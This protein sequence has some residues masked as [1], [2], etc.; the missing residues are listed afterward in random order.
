[1]QNNL[2]RKSLVCGIILL[3]IGLSITS[4]IGRNTNEAPINLSLDNDYVLAYWKFDTGSGNIAYDSSGNDYDGTVYG[5]TWFSHLAGYALD[6]D[7]VDDYIDLDAHSEDIGFNKTDDLVFSVWINST[8][9]DS[10]IYC[11]S[12][13]WGTSNPEMSIGLNSDGH[14]MMTAWVQACGLSLTSEGTYNNGEWH[15]VEIIYHGTT[16][17]P[18]VEL[19]VDNELDSSIKDWVCSFS[20]DQFKKAKIG[21]R[22]Y[23]A[24]KHFKGAIDRLKIIKYPG[25][26]QQPS[27]P[28]IDGPEFGMPGDELC[29]TFVSNDTEGDQV[30]YY[31]DWGD[32]EEEGWLGPYDPGV[33]LTRCHKYHEKGTYDIKAKTRDFWHDGWWSDPFPVDIGNYAP[34]QPDKPSGP[35]NGS[36]NI[37]YTYSTRSTDLEGDEIY[38]NWSW[39]D[40]TFSGWLGP[41]DSGQTV[42]A[43]HA[44]AYKGGYDVEVKATDTVG[45]S[46]W[47]DPLQ[48]S[49]VMS[50][51]EIGE[52]TG[53]LLKVNAVIKN[54][55]EWE[56]TDVS[57]HIDLVGGLIFSGGNSSGEIP[58]I[59]AG[60]ET[61]VS[62]SAI[63]GLGKPLVVVTANAQDGSHDIR[64]RDVFVFFII[65]L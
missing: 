18:T 6:F 30:E 25:G 7:G 19:Y 65:I 16:S 29:Y 59:P 9:T 28:V 24:T 41:Y 45:D 46:S 61:T 60:G 40:G 38:Y 52:I 26:N 23:D 15:Y 8:S 57:W 20:A 54:T 31:I 35:N 14:L 3:F 5:A 56:A 63:F 50:S 32:G 2:F 55:G 43:S 27:Q 33:E 49:I 12:D 37:E 48:V 42:T 39:D 21:R 4:S 17:K 53:G 44:W 47:S 36:I 13:S 64:E 11:L 34:E 10:Y 1:L 22:A 51:I 58:N 62:S